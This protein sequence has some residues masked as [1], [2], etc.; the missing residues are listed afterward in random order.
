MA[1][2]E[3]TFKKPA[4]GYYIASA[5]PFSGFY[6]TKKKA[7]TARKAAVKA[8]YEPSAIMAS[9]VRMI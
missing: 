4:A 3:P 6:H 8:G 7:V 1:Y 5:G 2:G 9:H